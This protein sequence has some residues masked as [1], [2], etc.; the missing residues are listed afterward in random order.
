MVRTLAAG[1]AFM[2]FLLAFIASVGIPGPA[3]NV[4]PA[5]LIGLMALAVA[6][7]PESRRP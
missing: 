2:A 4:V 6:V 3:K 1:I 7:I 5:V